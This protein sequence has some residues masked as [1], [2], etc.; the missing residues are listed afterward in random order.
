MQN[1][2]HAWHRGSSQS[3]LFRSPTNHYIRLFKSMNAFDW[4][5]S[6]SL[7]HPE[8]PGGD[9][10]F[11]RCSAT[12]VEPALM[13]GLESR[14]GNH[15]LCFAAGVPVTSPFVNDNNL[16]TQVRQNA[17]MVA[18]LA[19]IHQAAD[20]APGSCNMY[21][22]GQQTLFANQ[23]RASTW[24][25]SH[26][27]N[28]KTQ[29]KPNFRFKEIKHAIEIKEIIHGSHCTSPFPHIQVELAYD[30]CPLINV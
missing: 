13:A 8:K 26:S 6:N 29:D 10:I 18:D 28:R 1:Q 30:N 15:P 14:L 24:P 22:Q 20:S 11:S 21:W 5:L 19:G 7:R 3:V 12:T 16:G 17:G 23:A 4:L 25:N 27:D 2:P 9:D